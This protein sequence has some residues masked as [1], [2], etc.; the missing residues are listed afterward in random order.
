MNAARPLVAATAR[1]AGLVGAVAVMLTGCGALTGT[2]SG[3][4]T[5]GAGAADVAVRLRDFRVDAPATVTA[6]RTRFVLTG[7]GPTMHEFNV[8]RT[9]LPIAELPKGPSGLVAD[10]DGVPGFE[11]LDEAEG[12]DIG[13]HKS[14]TVELAPG[15]YV[16]YCNMEGHAEAGMLTALVVTG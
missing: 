11:H 15:R 16:L 14:L 4:S 7:E 13:G 1:F 12:I 9:D 3:A 8:A 10:T 6:G 5:G 2:S